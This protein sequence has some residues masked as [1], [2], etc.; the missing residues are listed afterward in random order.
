MGKRSQTWNKPLS[1]RMLD[2]QLNELV[3][4]SVNKPV[5]KVNVYLVFGFDDPNALLAEEFNG[6]DMKNNLF[7]YLMDKSLTSRIL[8]IHW[9]DMLD[10]TT[11]GITIQTFTD[12]GVLSNTNIDSRTMEW[13]DKMRMK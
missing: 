13:F 6:S 9:C 3:V 1:R 10:M 11:I 2:K 5:V 12:G 7:G 8:D 4:I